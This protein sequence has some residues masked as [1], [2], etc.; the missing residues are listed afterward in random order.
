MVPLHDPARAAGSW[1]CRRAGGASP[2]RGHLRHRRKG[3][4][5]PQAK[6]IPQVSAPNCILCNIARG[7][8][9]SHTLYEDEDI[10]VFHDIRPQA[11]VPLLA[12]PKEHVATLY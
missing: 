10:F 9:A 7:E 1:A 12:I 11:P 3:S 6:G 5:A 2:P 8:I 4:P